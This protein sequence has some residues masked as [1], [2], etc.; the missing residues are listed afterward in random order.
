M[1]DIADDQFLFTRYGFTVPGPDQ[2]AAPAG[3]YSRAGKRVFDIA[4]AL[5]LL[6]VVA[7]LIAGLW[8]ATRRDGGSG[9]FGHQRIGQNGRGFKCWKIRT[10]VMGAEEKLQAY[11]QAHP[12]AAQEW[13]D[14]RKLADDPRITAFGDF[15]RKTSLDELPQIWNVLAGEMSFVGPR[16][17]VKDEIQ[18]YGSG[19]C[20]YLAQKPG[21]TGLWQVSGRNSVSY[22]DRVAMDCRYMRR[23]S[24]FYDLRILLMTGRTVLKRTG[25]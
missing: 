22:E 15:L 9:F 14:T 6:P 11:L 20:F 21:I 12:A 24:F 25:C 4:L 18:K 1:K 23:I 17:V 16:P 3:F 7:P 2:S 13:E 10:M 5:L 8:V 19:A